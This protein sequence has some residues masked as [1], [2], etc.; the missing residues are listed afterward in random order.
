M[1]GMTNAMGGKDRLR[2]RVYGGTTPPPSPREY[3][4]YVKTTTPISWFE[5]NY[6]TRS[7]PTWNA[8]NGY[9]YIVSDGWGTSTWVSGN[10]INLIKEPYRTLYFVPKWC[11]QYINGTWYQM[12][13]YVYKNGG[14]V[15][16][17]D[18]KYTPPWDGTLFY[19]GDQYAAYTGG[20]VASGGVNWT[21]SP[22]LHYIN[23]VGTIYIRSNWAVNFDG[24]N[25]LKFTGSGQGANSGGSYVAHAGITD[26]AYSGDG[27][28]AHI[29]F[30][31]YGTYAIDCRSITG[32]HYI[33]FWASGSREQ[34]LNINKVWF[35]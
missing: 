24:H 14:W 16:F 2:Y 12:E 29:E 9:V 3:D 35:E 15:K 11:W 19:N 13:A 17:S 30:Q 33:Q 18:Y 20:W 5:L 10:E 23:E 8:G 31:S 6:W 26:N 1:I 28:L 4:F 21:T 34:Y 22:N 25:T 32:T 27:W 7:L